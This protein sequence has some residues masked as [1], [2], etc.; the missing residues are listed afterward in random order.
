[1]SPWE[2]FLGIHRSLE[3]NSLFWLQK[4]HHTEMA[5]NLI[6]W[7]FWLEIV[8]GS[9]LGKACRHRQYHHTSSGAF[10]YARH[11]IHSR[12]KHS[13]A[14]Q[15]FHNLNLFTEYITKNRLVIF[16]HRTTTLNPWLFELWKI[17]VSQFERHSLVTRFKKSVAEISFP[18]KKKHSEKKQPERVSKNF[19]G[20]ASLP[21]P[22]FW[23]K[24]KGL[25]NGTFLQ[26][27][28]FRRS[29]KSKTDSKIWQKKKFVHTC[30][31]KTNQRTQRT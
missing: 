19:N 4:I 16:L 2:K 29:H 17:E 20:G 8:L 1:M 21:H 6:C 27:I 15:A 5:L 26:N 28:S 12:Q 9:K 23:W 11:Q 22:M 13:Y 3:V 14:R 25:K 30:H 24:D 7:E 18:L 10:C 31:W